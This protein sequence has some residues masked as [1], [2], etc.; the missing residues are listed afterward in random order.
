MRTLRDDSAESPR[1]RR[2]SA[3]ALPILL[4]LLVPASLTQAASDAGQ[5]SFEQ[6]SADLTSADARIRLHAVQLLK[7][8]AYPE[9]AIPLARLLTDSQDDIQLEAIAAE[10]NIFLSDPIVPKKRVALVVEV[11]NPV[12]AEP[13]FAAGPNALGARSVPTEVLTGVRTAARDDNPRVA[14]EALY[15]FG[16]LGIQPAGAARRTLLQTAGPD[17]AAFIGSSDPAMRYAAVR[18]IGRLFARR[19]TDSSI[20]S[21]VGDAVITALN[22][23]DRAVKVAA[24]LALGAMR[25]ER[26]VQALTDL[27]S[28]YAKGE[29]AEAALYGLSQ[30]GHAA[31]APLFVAQLSSKNAS[32]RGIAIEGLARIGDRANLAAIQSALDKEHEQ[33]VTQAGAFAMVLLGN[34]T[35]DQ[36]ADWLSRARLRDQ[37]K[38]YLIEIAPGRTGSFAHQLLDSDPQIRIDTIDALGLAGDPAAIPVLEPLI[39]DRDPQVGRAAERAVARLGKPAQQP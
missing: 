12:Q 28:Y 15:A 19:P 23:N 17:I 10:L 2:G 4:A 39:K 16:T 7:G 1:G 25:Y 22:D 31:S 35:T 11:R 18:V 36:V 13:A 5:V 6:A 29:L 30:I 32:L 37:A 27:F 34:G 14:I 24:M 33:S 8:A 38:R 3:L 26:G 21:T 20:E 9:A